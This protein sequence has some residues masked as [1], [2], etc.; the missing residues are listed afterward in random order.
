MRVGRSR[1]KQ[2][3]Q[4]TLHALSLQPERGRELLGRI[5]RGAGGRRSQRFEISEGNRVE[6]HAHAPL[7]KGVS[8][9][10]EH[11]AALDGGE[12]IRVVDLNGDA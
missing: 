4:G 3:I 11:R 1:G 5:A 9:R 12:R 2:F 6:Q 8:E 10:I 7:T